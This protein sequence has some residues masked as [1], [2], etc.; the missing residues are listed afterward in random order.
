MN[1]DR[2]VEDIRRQ[3]EAIAAAGGEETQTLAARLVEPLDSAVRLAIQDA[4]AAAAED[5]TIEMAPGSVELR[6]R[7]REPEF[8]VT[9]P[10]TEYPEG[11]VEGSGGRDWSQKSPAT[12]DAA[13]DG[14]E[15]S[16]INLR[17]PDRLKSRVE[18]AAGAEGLSVNAWLVR[19]VAAV[20]ERG[21]AVRNSE[22]TIAR[23]AQRHT[24][25][26]R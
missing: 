26:V 12:G 13:D 1:I 19:V 20:V 22:R 24:G 6:L 15:I 17:L 11:D 2:L 18:E 16:R 9:L 5:I 7:G 8:V 25:W 10:P 21:P 23:G 3:L 14:S 4:L